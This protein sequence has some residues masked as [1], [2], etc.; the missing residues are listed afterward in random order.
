M[1]NTKKPSNLREEKAK[2]FEKT[3]DNF[4]IE[5]STQ[6]E[7][8]ELFVDATCSFSGNYY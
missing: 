3:F 5:T 6:N 2:L 8:K 7:K 4:E 1:S